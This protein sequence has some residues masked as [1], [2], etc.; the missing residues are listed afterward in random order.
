M[1]IK[2]TGEQNDSYISAT[3]IKFVNCQIRYSVVSECVI[4]H[5]A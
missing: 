5:N 4:Q 3:S 1:K 2:Q